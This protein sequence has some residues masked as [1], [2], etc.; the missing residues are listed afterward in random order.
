M[1]MREGKMEI[2]EHRTSVLNVWVIP[3][4]SFRVMWFSYT[5]YSTFIRSLCIIL[6]YYNSYIVLFVVYMT[7]HRVLNKEYCNRSFKLYLHK[8]T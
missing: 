7:F 5:L 6:N 1:R 8:V 4:Y 2:A 3:E